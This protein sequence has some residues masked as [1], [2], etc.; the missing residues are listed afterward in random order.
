MMIWFFSKIIIA[1]TFPM[2]I[3]DLIPYSLKRAS[4]HKGGEYQGACPNCGGADR[5]HVWPEQGDHGSYWCRGCGISGDA[6]QY[7]RD[8][9]GLG[10][11]EACLRLGVEAKEQHE[12]NTPQQ[13]KAAGDT[14]Q[15]RQCD[16]AA[17]IWRHHAAK[18]VE[19]AHQS[20]LTNPAQLEWLAARGIRLAAIEKH[21]LGWL[22]KDHYRDRSA[23]GL[24][25][26]LKENGQPK[27][28]WLPCGLVI[29]CFQVGTLQRLRIRRPIVE[30]NE[31][32]YYLVPGSGTMPMVLNPNA[33]A[34]VI[35]EAELDAILLDAVAGDL[36]GLISQGN[37]SAKPDEVSHVSLDR[38]GCI[39]V[40]LDSD[41]AG[42]KAAQWWLDKYATAERWP[43][44]GAKDPG[45]A[46]KAG[47]DLRAWIMAGLPPAMTIE[48]KTPA[49]EPV[50]PPQPAAENPPIIHQITAKDG[51]TIHI[52]DDATA[53]QQL[54]AAGKIVFTGKEMLQLK[55]LPPDP[56]TAARI[57][58]LKE[59]FPG[60]E[61][62]QHKLLS[63]GKINA[64]NMR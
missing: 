61:I 36:V 28:L 51:R 22:D 41:K 37:S 50:S 57:L 33:A 45:D 52:T 59:I 9:D 8:V 14:W 20:L 31:M 26:V 19:F 6:I 44:V 15:P 2:T 62:H 47:V 1:E 48:T 29:P 43:V 16:S 42:A 10:Y 30:G 5:F 58:D 27:K 13:R 60:M 53:Y 7:L 63:K 24:P 34:L 12:S 25:P 17:D 4:S 23:W 64:P 35:V 39:L 40:A 11:K 18:L 56:A 54:A 3:L 38:A 55:D 21:R 46:F 32:R 49:P